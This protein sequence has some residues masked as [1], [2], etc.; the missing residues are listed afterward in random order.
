MRESPGEPRRPGA[1]PQVPFHRDGGRQGRRGRAA[2]RAELQLLRCKELGGVVYALEVQG[3]QLYLAT[4]A[5]LTRVDLTS[6]T[7]HLVLALALP[8]VSHLA[9]LPGPR[10]LLHTP[11]CVLLASE[12]ALLHLP[13][14]GRGASS[15]GGALLARVTV[16]GGAVI[17]R[18]EGAA[19]TPLPRPSV[20]SQ[21]Y[22]PP[23]VQRVARECRENVPTIP[24]APKPAP[25]SPKCLAK[26]P[27]PVPK[28]PRP[29]A[30]PLPSS[31]RAERDY[32]L[33]LDQVTHA[34]SLA[35]PTVQVNLLL[36]P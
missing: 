12:G 33:L 2:G 21:V 7:P 26:G 14:A 20:P 5:G 10:A 25:R 24:T 35:P 29:A 4:Q 3:G 8:P 13:V 30:M 36:T 9:L 17:Y 31:A 28:S 23:S 34:C 18:V 19:F 11:S 15:P 6:L 22:R 16:N 27:K 1:R 32:E